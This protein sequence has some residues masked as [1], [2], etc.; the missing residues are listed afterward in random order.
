MFWTS[1]NFNHTV[2]NT[3]N[4]KLTVCLIQIKIILYWNSHIDVLFSIL[5]NWVWLSVSLYD[6]G[7]NIMWKDSMKTNKVVWRFSR[8]LNTW[9]TL[10]IM[11]GLP[12]KLMFFSI[13]LSTEWIGFNRWLQHIPY[14]YKSVC[15]FESWNRC[16]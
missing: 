5:N 9:I 8:Y 15:F 10:T 14:S 16:M 4:D 1:L 6:A 12:K 13:T 11:V 3:Y 7:V 2:N